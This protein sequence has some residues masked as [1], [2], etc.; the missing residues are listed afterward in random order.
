[1]T[2]NIFKYATKELSQDAVV[3]WLVAYARDTADSR[4]ADG[5]HPSYSD[6]ET[7]CNGYP[8][9]Y[10]CAGEIR[11]AKVFLS[12]GRTTPDAWPMCWEIP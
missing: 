1:M 12:C 7:Q 11:S 9:V 10:D 2:P 3:C 6:T 5:K 4:R 8:E